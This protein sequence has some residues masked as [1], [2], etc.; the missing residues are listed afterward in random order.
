MLSFEVTKNYG[1]MSLILVMIA[2]HTTRMILG[3]FIFQCDLFLEL[4]QIYEKIYN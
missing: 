1:S 2:G 3:S 4:K